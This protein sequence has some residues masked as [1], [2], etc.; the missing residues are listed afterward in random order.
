LPDVSGNPTSTRAGDLPSAGPYTPP[1]NGRGE[2]G[3]TASVVEPPGSGEHTGPIPRPHTQHVST[4]H[5]TT[6][7]S[8][9]RRDR[10]RWGPIW[11]GVL[12]VLTVFIVLQLLFF[13]LGWLDL[14]FNG[15]AGTGATAGIVTGV[16]ALIAFFVGREQLDSFARAGHGWE[17]TTPARWRGSDPALTGPQSDNPTSAFEVCRVCFVAARTSATSPYHAV[18]LFESSRSVAIL[19]A[20]PVGVR[21]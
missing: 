19:L 18:A 16:L 7:R 15:A 14:G 4:E 5:V 17:G 12:A 11:A 1:A 13:A 20:S 3:A 2:S 8:E 21:R 9:D 10:V 6:E